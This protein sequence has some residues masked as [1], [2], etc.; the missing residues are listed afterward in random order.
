MDTVERHSV[1]FFH[2]ASFCLHYGIIRL[3]LDVTAAEP[4][5]RTL[6]NL[7]ERIPCPKRSKIRGKIKRNRP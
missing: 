7:G 5:S 1:H 4:A 6:T 3:T 2:F